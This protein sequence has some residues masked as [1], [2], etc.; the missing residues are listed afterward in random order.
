MTASRATRTTIDKTTAEKKSRKNGAS[1]KWSALEYVPKKRWWWFVALGWIGLTLTFLFLAWGEWSIAAV[2]SAA[3]VTL[4]VMYSGKPRV[5]DYTLTKKEL[6]VGKMTWTLKQ[7][8]A[9]TIEEISQGKNRESVFVLVLLPQG[10]F[11]RAR[12]VYLTG[13]LA[14]DARISDTLST[15]LP[16]DEAERYQR[17]ER[18][19]NRAGR[20]LKLS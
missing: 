19:L 14:V 3:T 7:F 8:R 13:D 12:D 15:E 1:L 4:I 20:W 18:L 2:T 9:F 17:T 6:T 10:R 11:A 16:F 5:W